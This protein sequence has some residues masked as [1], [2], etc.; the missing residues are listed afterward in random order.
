[1]SRLR[2]ECLQISG[3]A[4]ATLG[5]ELERIGLHCLLGTVNDTGDIITFQYISFLNKII[6]LA[7]IVPNFHII[8]Y[9]LPNKLWPGNKVIKEGVPVW[10]QN[11]AGIFIN[12][13]PS[14][15]EIIFKQ[16]MK[17]IGIAPGDSLCILPLVIEGKVTGVF[18][19]WGL[20]IE[21]K[22]TSTLMIFAH[23]VAEILRKTKNFE[24]E[25]SRANSLAK[26]NAMIIA[27][28]KVA[29]RLETT[30]N[31]A[32]V[33]DT[34]GNELGKADINCMV[35][36]LD[37]DKQFL[38]IEYLSISQDIYA[39]AEKL[40]AVWPDEIRIPRRLWPTDK[41]VTEKTPYWDPDPIGSTSKMFPFIPKK[42]FLKTFEMAGMNPNDQVCYLPMISEEDVIGILAVWGPSIRQDDIPGLSVFANQV[43]TAIRNTTLYNQAQH[44]ILIRT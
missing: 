26:T 23:Q 13:F 20:G 21:E 29:A 25:L 18:S 5:E 7:E 10:Y 44:E 12:M 3:K 4:L 8:G 34:L 28:S 39:W 16:A 22:D 11:P 30:S 1:M 9:E 35:G 27:L 33:F 36:T 24:D 38:K 42:L 14:V 43:A 15:P 19:I 31:M 2:W 37:E 40:G 41:A 17:K 32:D 6:K